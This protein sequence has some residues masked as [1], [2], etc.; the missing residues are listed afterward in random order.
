VKKAS[1][2]LVVA[3][4]ANAMLDCFLSPIT[5]TN[6]IQVDVLRTSP[7]LQR[8][9]VSFICPPYAIQRSRILSLL[10]KVL[11]SIWLGL[12]GDF[13]CVHAILVFPHLYLASIISFLARKP[14]VYMVVASDFEFTGKGALLQSLT[15]KLAK[16]SNVILV[17]NGRT[18]TYLERQEYPA[19]R[20]V[21]YRLLDLVDTHPFYPL[22][23]EKTNDL[24]VVSRLSPDKHVDLFVDIVGLVRASIPSVKAA[25]VGDGP[26]RMKLDRHVQ[27][28]GLTRNIRFHGFVP[29][30]TTLN[31]I[32]NSSKIFVLNSSHEGGPFTVIEAMAAGVCCIS[33]KV[34]HVPDVIMH[35]RNGF[36]VQEYD[37]VE[38]YV[39]IIL[40]LLDDTERLRRIQ[41]EASHIKASQKPNRPTRF[42]SEFTSHIS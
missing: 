31:Q 33:S 6:S 30:I 19:R 36:I 24:V 21:M 12:K 9:N 28:K 37:D 1:R 2:V 14:L 42:W 18:Y 7:G 40:E 11:R 39:R 41:E 4:L 26:M 29:S 32:L 22:E 38:T 34:G 13:T 23:S 5:S 10:W 8:E 25:I 20:I 35:S 15:P 17:P 27:E 3:G 16:R